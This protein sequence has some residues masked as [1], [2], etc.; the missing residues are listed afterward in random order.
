M[1][2]LTDMKA[3]AKRGFTKI[4]RCIIDQVL[5]RNGV[6]T[7]KDYKSISSACET[8]PSYV[9]G[10]VNGTGDGG[11]RVNAEINARLQYL[12]IIDRQRRIGYAQAMLSDQL[13]RRAE[14]N[15]PLSDLDPMEILDYIRKETSAESIIDNRRQTV[16]V[17]DFSSLSDDR[18]IAAIEKLQGMIDTGEIKGIL[19]GDS[20]ILDLIPVDALTA[21][22][23][24]RED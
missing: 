9:C 4:Q 2:I 3:I 5:A 1:C 11:E 20:E 7:P 8:T 18:L 15:E 24:G 6:V 10:I 21:D 17:F 14:N 16:N 23:G 22:A 13:T 19:D 12:P